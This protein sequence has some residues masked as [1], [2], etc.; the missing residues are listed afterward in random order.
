MKIVLHGIVA[1]TLAWSG[2]ASAAPFCGKLENHYGPFDYRTNKANLPLV[3]NAHF[4]EEVER[5]LRGVTATE[6]GGDLDYTLR[7]F[8][9]HHR[10]LATLVNVSLR[11]KAL[12]LKQ[13]K[14]PVECYFM[15]A[16]QF[17]GTD[18]VVRGLYGSYLYGMGKHDKALAMY[19]EAIALDPDNAMLNYNIGLA[20]LK[21]TDFPRALEHAH[22]AYAQGYPLPGLKNQLV[23]A[24]KWTEPEPQPLAAEKTAQAAE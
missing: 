3:E 2:L 18:A 15:R 10:A 9:N 8:P 19:Q 21:K 11:D 17:A 14:Y 13:M 4:T 23:K 12:Q 6:I 16:Q 5:G 1:A 22:K 7:A 24:G 20:Y